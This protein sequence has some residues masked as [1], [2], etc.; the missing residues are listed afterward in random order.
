MSARS[1]KKTNQGPSQAEREAEM[2]TPQQQTKSPGRGFRPP[3]PTTI[4][5]MHEKQELAT[6]N[7]RLAAYIDKVR[8]LE[9]DNNRLT[10]KIQTS[11]EVVH[12]ESS[13]IKGLFEGELSDAR[14]LLDETA[15]DKAKL[16]I[17]VGKLQAELKE[18][19]DKCKRLE[20]DGN[21][22]DRRILAAE[23][24]A[25][26]LQARLNDA[27]NQRK[28]WENEYNKLKKE[29]A[30][31][32]KQLTTVRKQLEEETILRVDLQNRLQSLK[33][34]LAFKT[35]V[36]EQEILE[37]RT[38]ARVE[39]EEVDGRLQEE[40][41]SRLRE[42]VQDMRAEN[43]AVVQNAKLETEAYF[44]RKLKEMRELAEK[45]DGAA[46][47]ARS[48]L[49]T[50]RKKLEEV[51]GQVDRFR[52]QIST[53]EA[54]IR[55]LENTLDRERGEHEATVAA[56]NAEIERL[57]DAFEEQMVEYR[58]LL[59]IKIQLDNEIATY[60][61]LLESEETRLNLSTD[62]QVTPFSTRSGRKTLSARKRKRGEDDNPEGSFIVSKAQAS[63]GYSSQATS[64]G[65]VEVSDTDTDGKFIKLFNSSDK[66]IP[67]NGWK[68]QHKAGE[69]E[70]VFKFYRNATLKAGEYVTVWSSD[71]ET[72][73]NPPHDLVM[74]NKSWGVSDN[75]RTALL[76]AEGEEV[77]S[78]E[79]K[80]TVLRQAYFSSGTDV[81][82]SG[83]EAGEYYNYQSEERKEDK[84]FIM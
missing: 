25:S 5:R 17:D 29:L 12:R 54:R 19:K 52:A 55:D 28:H 60:R 68:I 76:N 14:K 77:A 74:K 78:R 63:S 3:S 20:Q 56:K 48:E 6:L 73:H 16:Q 58:E 30:E 44:T 34:E 51:T 9:E 75:M 37:T 64:S 53:L 13:K 47:F 10:K 1:K 69:D 24:H 59:G 71:T 22:K 81:V 67:I 23:S 33:E 11:E 82:D 42:A 36:H 4:S 62:S 31:L 40:Y 45:N 46:E 38:R 50:T 27:V 80:K 18:V 57:R 83:Y 39:I 65:A 21:E 2:S 66:D 35:Q 7:D 26:D 32:E 61:K 70:V 84:C 43:D 15:K 8:R 41:D 72:T 49:R 79:L